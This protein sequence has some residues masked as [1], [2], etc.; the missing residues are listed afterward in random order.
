VV[1]RVDR[2]ALRDVLASRRERV[3]DSRHGLDSA[4][5][6]LVLRVLRSLLDRV[7]MRGCG[8]RLV[9]GRDA[10]VSATRR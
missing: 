2:V 9:L 10:E 6:P 7:R 4:R 3:L 1:L 8:P 5:D